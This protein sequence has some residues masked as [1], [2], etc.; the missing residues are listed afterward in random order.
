MGAHGQNRSALYS[1]G[2]LTA[3]DIRNSTAKEIGTGGLAQVAT[4]YG[5]LSGGSWIA[6]SW[7]LNGLPITRDLVVGN[8]QNGGNLTGWIL[9]RDLLLPDGLRAPDFYE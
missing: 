5:G 4:Y 6:T 1:A 9:D 2:A 8:T 7:A 3:F